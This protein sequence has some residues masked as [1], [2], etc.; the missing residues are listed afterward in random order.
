[1]FSLVS[2]SCQRY[3]ALRPSPRC[4]S[5]AELFYTIDYSAWCLVRFVCQS[6]TRFVLFLPKRVCAI[7]CCHEMTLLFVANILKNNHY[8]CRSS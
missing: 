5:F 6:I 8:E 1:M 3:E 7:G 4:L 2:F